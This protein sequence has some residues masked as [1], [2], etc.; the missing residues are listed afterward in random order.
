MKDLSILVCF[1]TIAGHRSEGARAADAIERL[2]KSLKRVPDGPAPLDGVDAVLLMGNANW[3]PGMRRQLRDLAR[4]ERPIVALWHWEPLPPSRESGLRPPRLTLRERA[5]ILL[6]DRRATDVYTNDR[7]IR[8]LM[9]QGV[10]DVLIAS[11][12]GRVEYLAENGVQAE[13]VPLGYSAEHGRDLS[14]PRDIDALFLGDL[15][16]PRRRRALESLRRAGVR[17]TSCGDWFDPMFWDESRTRLLNRAKIFLNVQRFSG[18]FSGLRLILGMAN[19]ALVVSEPM[20][21]PHP[22]VAGT[23]YVS[24]RVD[25]MPAAIEYYLTHEEER[26]RI[27]REGHRLVTEELTLE[28]SARRILELISEQVAR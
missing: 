4:R 19:K 12:L 7:L 27:V 28:R 13:Y 20:C 16:I 2:V 8:G 26:L 21:K 25:E 3:F 11:T 10:V 6:R 24:A 9:R 18:E 15:K 14:L 23:H 1:R 5:K 22:F 17:L